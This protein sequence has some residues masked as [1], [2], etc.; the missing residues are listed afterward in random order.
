MPQMAA[1][2]PNLATNDDVVSAQ[3]KCF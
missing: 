3:S 2:Y 1:I